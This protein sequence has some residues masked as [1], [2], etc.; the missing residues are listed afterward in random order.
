MVGAQS[1]TQVLFHVIEKKTDFCICRPPIP[2][3]KP[4]PISSHLSCATPF[5]THDPPPSRAIPSPI[6]AAHLGLTPRIAQV[7]RPPLPIGPHHPAPSAGPSPNPSSAP[8]R[9]GAHLGQYFV[10]CVRDGSDEHTCAHAWSLTR[11]NPVGD[12]MV[13]HVSRSSRKALPSVADGGSRDEQGS[14]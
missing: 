6:S 7:L 4:A 3:H 5:D 14:S 10:D 9:P 13:S 11:Q 1:K 8:S 12:V 2:T